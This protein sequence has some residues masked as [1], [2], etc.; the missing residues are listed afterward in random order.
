[1]RG[2]VNEKTGEIA[3]SEKTG[4]SLND[5]D[6]LHSVSSIRL[7]NYDWPLY[8]VTIRDIRDSKLLQVIKVANESPDSLNLMTADEATN[9]LLENLLWVFLRKGA[10]GMVLTMETIRKQS[11][12]TTKESITDMLPYLVGGIPTVLAVL[13]AM[14]LV[15]GGETEINPSQESPSPDQP[16]GSPPEQSKQTLKAGSTNT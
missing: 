3:M 5:L 12:N 15:T 16:D 8:P 4:F 1:M 11:W 6:A 2:G 9:D 13:N 7:G 14:Q 10:P